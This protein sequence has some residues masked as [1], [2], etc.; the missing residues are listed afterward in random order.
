[1]FVF[2]DQRAFSFYLTTQLLTVTPRQETKSVR[3]FSNCGYQHKR[4]KGNISSGISECSSTYN[5]NSD[6]ICCGVLY[7]EGITYASQRITLP[8]D[9]TP[10][11][12][13]IKLF[14][15]ACR[16]IDQTLCWDRERKPSVTIKDTS[17]SRRLDYVN[18]YKLRGGLTELQT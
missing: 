2:V 7:E 1:M 18:I 9:N 13:L 8:P 6:R 17:Q 12:W 14:M 4:Q 10:F 15:K 5:F 16:P 3:V 11:S